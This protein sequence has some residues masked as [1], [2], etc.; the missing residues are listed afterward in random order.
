MARVRRSLR[1]LRVVFRVLWG[2]PA[3]R[4]SMGRWWPAAK[5]RIDG[6]SMLLHPADNYTERYMW[7]RG[8]RDEAASI[9][10]LTLLVAGKKSLV[11]DIGANCGAYTLPLATASGSDSRI[12]AF[13][14]NPVMA[15]RLR[16]NL[17]MND[18]AAKVEVEQVA[19]GADNGLGYLHLGKF[20]LGQS[21]L[22]SVES[23]EA[24]PVSVRP[25]ASYL[26]SDGGSYQVFVMK[27]D[28]EGQEDQVLVPFLAAISSEKM[29]DAILVETVLAD[30]WSMDLAAFL[31]QRGYV[32]LFPGEDQNTLFLRIETQAALGRRL[33]STAIALDKQEGRA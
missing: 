17:A 12:V 16:T 6:H 3:L 23:A 9:G 21:T 8:A 13:E 30:R 4:A 19:V 27:V 24:V 26:R 1:L 2:V 5:L 29:P 25:L 20:N 22:R 31:E 28:V 14:P 11:F 15:G 10:R 18:L 33:S 7:R 32:P